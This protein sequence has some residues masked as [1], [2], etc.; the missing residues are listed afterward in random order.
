MKAR[1]KPVI[2]DVVRFVGWNKEIEGT[3]FY[4]I[5]DSGSAFSNV[6]SWLEEALIKEKIKSNVPYQW[7]IYVSTL[8]G[9]M[10]ADE[11][12]YIIQGVNGEIYPCKPDIFEKTYEIIED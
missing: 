9:D 12:D 7:R 11:G 6:P 5:Y 2:V 8:E 4:Q 10:R 1:K 3:P